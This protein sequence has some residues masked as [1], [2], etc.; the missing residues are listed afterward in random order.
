MPFHH[1]DAARAVPCTEYLLTTYHSQFWDK[2]ELDLY[3]EYLLT[4]YHSQV[5]EQVELDLYTEFDLG[6]VEV[7]HS[8]GCAPSV[9]SCQ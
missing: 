6:I 4:T 3:T 2:V 9:H 8:V 5:W 1:L 7:N